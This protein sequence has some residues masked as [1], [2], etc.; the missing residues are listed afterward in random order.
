MSKSSSPPDYSVD[1]VLRKMSILKK[2]DINRNQ[3]LVKSRKITLIS[4]LNSRVT[5]EDTFQGLRIE[6]RHMWT[7][8]PNKASASKYSRFNGKQRFIWKKDVI[9]S[10]L[11]QD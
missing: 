10:I 4:L 6:C 3:V 2:G 1:R 8:I 5:K 11:I 7:K 9:R